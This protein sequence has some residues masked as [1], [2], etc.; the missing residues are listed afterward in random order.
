MDSLI[1][2]YNHDLYKMKRG[3][4]TDGLVVMDSL[5]VQATHVQFFNKDNLPDV[6]KDF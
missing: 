1:I 3:N 4:F 6:E 2:F 5:L